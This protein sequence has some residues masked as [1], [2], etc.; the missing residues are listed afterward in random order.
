MDFELPLETRMLKD[1]V[2]DFVDTELIPIEMTASRGEDIAP[3]LLK[4]LQDKARERGLWLLHVPAE[5]GG[6]GLGLLDLCVVN[7]ELA[8]SKAIP[9]RFN[10]VFGPFVDPIL[11]E[12]ANED[13]KQR[14]LLPNIRNEIRICF[15]LTEP[16]AGADP[17]GMKTRAVRDGDHYILNGSKRFISVAGISDYA[18]LYAVTDPQ[19]GARGGISCFI[20][21]LKAK[22][23]SLPRRWPTMMDDAPW[24]INLDDVRV[25]A[26]NLLGE[27]GQGFA[28][29]QRSLTAQRLY[30]QTAWSLGVARRALEIAMDYAKVRVT[31]G[32]P[33]G[34]RQAVQFMIADSAMDI[35]AMRLMIYETAWKHDRG[36]DIRDESYMA[37]IYAVEAGGRVV[38]RAIQILGGIGLSTDL[39]LEYFYR[40]IRSIRI[41]EGATEVLRWRLARNLMRKNSTG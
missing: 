35:R 18:L 21:D 25:P 29:G 15:A 27:E 2:R 38:D 3:D 23:V 1:L 40:Q 17:A 16:D 6:M 14:F 7:E 34:E 30:G 5:L 11:I 39:P 22:G 4:S 19:K 36:E 12:S 8:R 24:E 9:F 20:V 10:E 41:T 37:K 31:F 33:I 32:Q 26:A 13:Q 28:L